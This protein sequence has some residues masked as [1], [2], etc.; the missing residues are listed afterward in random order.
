MRTMSSV[1]ILSLNVWCV[2]Q[3][4]SFILSVIAIGI[5]SFAILVAFAGE[6]NVRH[7]EI[8]LPEQITQTVAFQ[9]DE[10]VEIAGISG[11]AEAHNPILVTRSGDFAYVLAVRNDGTSPH[12]LYIEGLEVQTDLLMPGDEDTITV[13]PKKPGTYDYYD[14]TQTLKKLG[15]LKVVQVVPRDALEE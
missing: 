7:V 11:T 15:Q 14:K 12:R 2:K 10:T 4:I 8:Y 9:E 5:A 6:G 13:V 1:K 3:G